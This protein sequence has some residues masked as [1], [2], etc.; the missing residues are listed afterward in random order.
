MKKLFAL[1]LAALMLTGI[2][3]A[4]GAE[5]YAGNGTS[6]DAVTDMEMEAPAE[7]IYGSTADSSSGS[8]QHKDQKL[9]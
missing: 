7:G 4:C 9:I 8:T 2:L 6:M 3:T 1:F 5:S